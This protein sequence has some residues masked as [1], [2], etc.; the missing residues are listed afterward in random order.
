MG[1]VGPEIWVGVPPKRAAKKPMKIAPYR[2]ALAP[3]P[4]LTPKARANGSATM[5]AV[6]PPKRSPRKWAKKFFMQE[7]VIPTGN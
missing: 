6:T 3:R 5:P 1:A 2:P 7:R 4:E